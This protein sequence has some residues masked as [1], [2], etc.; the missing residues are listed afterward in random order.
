MTDDLTGEI[1]HF[2]HSDIIGM[3]GFREL[4][5]WRNVEFTP[6]RK[7][8]FTLWA[9]DVM[10]LGPSTYLPPTGI[11]EKIQYPTNHLD[12]KPQWDSVPFWY[13]PVRKSHGPLCEMPRLKPLIYKDAKW[14]GKY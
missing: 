8:N 3:K 1:Y 7:D 11:T 2:H 14:T 13:H 9:A 6:T 5:M 12:N 10:D 4:L